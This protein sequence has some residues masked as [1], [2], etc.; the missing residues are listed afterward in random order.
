MKRLHSIRLENNLILRETRSTNLT[1][2]I[3]AI[4]A[5]KDFFRTVEFWMA[6]GSIEDHAKLLVEKA[7]KTR[8]EK[9]GARFGLWL[10]NPGGTKSGS[11]SDLIGQFNI[12]DMDKQNKK[13]EVGYWLAEN[14]N[15]KGYASKALRA[16][17]KFG[18]EE[19]K[20]HR[21]EAKTAT[22]NRSSIR[23]LERTGFQREALLR[24]AFKIGNRFVDD[25]LYSLLETDKRKDKL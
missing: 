14:H 16:L 13:A 17:I 5:N 15:G 24:G 23:L 4:E 6:E 10:G 12:F 11:K 1:K 9:T 3:E 22:T 25:Y 8:R 20:L 21:L 2:L 19:L 7:E 18:F